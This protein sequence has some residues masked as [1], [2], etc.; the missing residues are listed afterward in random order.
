MNPVS[1]SLRRKIAVLEGLE[2]PDADAP[3]V[4][5]DVVEDA[6]DAP[7]CHDKVLA[8]VMGWDDLA[9]SSFIE[10]VLDIRIARLD[11]RI[12]T[13]YHLD[14]PGHEPNDTLIVNVATDQAR[15]YCVHLKGSLLLLPSTDASKRAIHN[16]LAAAT[17]SYREAPAQPCKV[18]GITVV[19]SHSD[20]LFAKHAVLSP[21]RPWVYSLRWGPDIDPWDCVEFHFVSLPHF[22]K[23]GGA[24]AQLDRAPSADPLALSAAIEAHP[25]AQTPR[26]FSFFAWCW[27]MA[28][29][30]DCPYASIPQCVKTHPGVLPI[31]NRLAQMAAPFGPEG[32]EESE[33]FAKIWGEAAI[34]RS[35]E[36]QEEHLR[37]EQ[38]RTASQHK[39]AAYRADQYR[40]QMSALS[41]PGYGA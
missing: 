5:E 29:H 2:V 11:C 13:D 16:G 31:W 12:D 10:S 37:G 30:C 8:P 35:L 22:L 36:M 28:H 27:F 38:D 26:D 17:A 39:A 9:L 40:A 3:A 21:T 15:R 23:Y 34:A 41:A 19:K 18:V 33:A 1:A 7:L 6:K 32:D 4:T 14:R 24:A 20:D 25:S